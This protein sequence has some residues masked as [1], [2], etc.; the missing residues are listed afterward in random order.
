MRGG[1]RRGGK[2]THVISLRNNYYTYYTY[3]F[4]LLMM[5]T[6]PTEEQLN[7]CPLETTHLL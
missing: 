1:K 3:N 6:F 4:G 7:N 5:L 2:K